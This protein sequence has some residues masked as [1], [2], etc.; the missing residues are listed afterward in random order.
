MTGRVEPV[1][2]AGSRPEHNVPRL[3][4]ARGKRDISIGRGGGMD[5]TAVAGEGGV[6]HSVIRKRCPTSWF[7]M[8]WCRQ[9]L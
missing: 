1:L 6:L 3:L 2:S 5:K 7:E 8:A 9:P 4:L